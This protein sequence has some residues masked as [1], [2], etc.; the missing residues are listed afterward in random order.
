MAALWRDAGI[1]VLSADDL[2][3]RAVSAESPGLEDVVQAFGS[4]FLTSSGTL[5]RAALRRHVF[6]DDSART[7]LEAI[8]HPRIQVF[9]DRWMRRQIAG[10]AQL[11]VSE[12]PLLFETG[13]EHDFDH[14]VVVHAA[15]EERF[16]RLV[17]DRGVP[18]AEAKLIMVAQMD[19][20]DQ[21]SRGGLVIDNDGP[22][23]QLESRARGVL[24]ELR[25]L[26]GRTGARPGWMRMD[27]HMHTEASWD[28]LSD[29]HA[30]LERAKS[31]GMHRI[32]ITDHNVLGTA[33][34]MAEEFPD[35][36]IAGEEVKTAEGIDVIGLYLKREIP[37]GTPAAEVCRL[38]KDQGGVVYLPHPFARGKGGAGRFTERLA[39]QL[40]VVEVFNARMHPEHLNEPAEDFA[41]RWGLPRG[42]G[43]DAHTVGEV[44]G[45]FVE[46][47]VH[48]NQP[49]GLLRALRSSRVRGRTAPWAVHLASTW[50]KVRKRLP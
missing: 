13:M 1:P 31:R 22:R 24:D 11:V 43:S 6:A 49:D 37:R 7:R 9:R 17:E 21:R 42:A 20:Q 47:P 2:A 33:L 39:P 32:A 44:A 18:A 41:A 28:C 12:I 48:D 46:V 8:L 50:A 40:D 15:E 25:G 36:V 14:V 38:I 29:P 10:G 19:P 30:L 23:E 34:R 27:L 45:G 16:R 3:R 35:E 5:D 26:A 4:D